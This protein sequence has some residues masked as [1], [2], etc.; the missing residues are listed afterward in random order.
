[1]RIPRNPKQFEQIN[2]LGNVLSTVLGRK[3]PITATGG[4]GSST[5]ITHYE[6]D[7][8]FATDYYPFGNPMSWST[9]DS[10]GGR[11]Y[12]G[13]GYRF[14]FNGQEKEPELGD[15]YAFEYRIHDARLGRFLSVDPLAPEYPMLSPYCFA[16]NSPIKLID[17]FGLGPGDVVVSFGGGDYM[18]TNDKGGAPTIIR[19]VNEQ[20]IPQ[21]GGKSQAFASQY[22]GVSPDIAGDLDKAT[23]G[24]YDFIKANYNVNYHKKVEGG[25]VIIQGYSMGG[26]M[27]NHLAKRLQGDNIQVD[28]LITVDAAAAFET[29]KVDRTISANVKDNLNIFQTTPSIVESCGGSNIAVLPAPT[30]KKTLFSEDPADNTRVAK[31]IMP[32]KIR[33]K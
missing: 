1:M 9:P 17:V 3:T 27:A 28:L 4:S 23:Q 12:S 15:Y 11:M 10:S 20:H 5:T 18:G 2:H 29:H 13:G 22:W 6:G 16:G 33:I 19:K 32:T 14:G 7:V 26:V 21:E 31:P 25:K 30:P 24:A 8:V